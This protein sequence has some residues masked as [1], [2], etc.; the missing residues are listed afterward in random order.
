MNK[1]MAA[2]DAVSRL[3]S[4]MTIGM[5]GWGARRKPMAL[6]REILRSDLRDLTIVAF[7]GP[8]VGMLAAAGR[9]KKLIFGFVSLD[10]IPLEP[11]FRKAREGGLLQVEEY[12]EGMVVLGLVAAGQRLPFLPTRAGL[13][14]DVMRHNPHLKT[15]TSPYEDGEVLVAMKAL[16]LDAALIHVNRAD[17]L[18]NTQS[19]GHDFYFDALMARAADA[20]YATTEYLVDRLDLTH[21]DQAQNNQVERACITGVIASPGGAHPTSCP[22]EYGWDQG[23]LRTYAGSAAQGGFDAYSGEWLAGDEAAYLARVGGIDAIRK[24]KPVEM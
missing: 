24:L 10:F 22:D 13:G 23:H 4:G 21:S 9:V 17:R 1:Q 3:K 20:C 15:I 2:R 8:E 6:V 11:Y 19:D 18:G 12:D 5:G 16:R 7:G 14:T